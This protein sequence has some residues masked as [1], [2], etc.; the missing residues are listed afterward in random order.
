MRM[1][2]LLF[3]GENVAPETESR[4]EWGR[5]SRKKNL[6]ERLGTFKINWTN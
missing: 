3:L 4:L 5:A 6:E 2:F 1:R